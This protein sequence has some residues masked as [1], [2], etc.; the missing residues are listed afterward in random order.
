MRRPPLRWHLD[1]EFNLT[2]WSIGARYENRPYDELMWLIGLGP[3]LLVITGR[4][5]E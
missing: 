2:W 4:E 1:W 3:L 5:I